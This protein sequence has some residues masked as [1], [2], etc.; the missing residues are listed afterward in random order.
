MSDFKPSRYFSADDGDYST[1]RSGADAI[2]FDI[3]EINK[4]FDPNASHFD[5]TRGGIGKTNLK[6]DIDEEVRERVREAEFEHIED[7][8]F[9]DAPTE[10]STAILTSGTIYEALK[11]V[12]TSDIQETAEKAERT[13]AEAKETA[14]RA[15][16]EA[17]K[18]LDVPPDP[19]AGGY[20][21]V[22]GFDL[23]GNPLFR[24]TSL[25]EASLTTAGIAKVGNGLQSENGAIA[26]M[27]A[28]QRDIDA[29][30]SQYKPIT[31]SVLNYAVLSAL[32]DEEQGIT[33][34]DE[35]KVILLGRIGALLGVTIG[36]G[37]TVVTNIPVASSSGYGVGK[38]G[39]AYGT[40]ISSGVF[41]IQ[42]AL[43]SDID[44]RT[45][46]YKPVT[47][48]N[49]DYALL[50][51]FTDGKGAAWTATQ[52]EAG[53]KRFGA[54]F[55]EKAWNTQT[56]NTDGHDVNLPSLSTDITELIVKVKGSISNSKAIYFT[57]YRNSS[58]DTSIELSATFTNN[59]AFK[60]TNDNGLITAEV[61]Q[62]AAADSDKIAV[63]KSGNTFGSL[64]TGKITGFRLGESQYLAAG[65]TVEIIY[66]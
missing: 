11:D 21:S 2:E 37:S 17:L 57:P 28:S 59:I 43:N 32:T 45:S 16:E 63:W 56:I 19:F 9:D 41:A 27:T 44:S 34:S 66:R 26:T 18:K 15:E 54:K 1:G 30:V 6:F 35:Q 8:I 13:A 50:K 61:K 10:G 23:E 20:L 36:G 55:A 24:F 49:L 52:K 51:A 39:T 62:N 4:M 38:V 33:F 3:D 31:P 40:K 22:A 64:K 42:N 48:S 29:R 25:P 5:G 53:C 12:D 7:I 58:L 60:L 47:P 65:S 46:V 14:E